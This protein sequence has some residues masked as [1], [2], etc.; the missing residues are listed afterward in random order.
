MSPRKEK[1]DPPVASSSEPE[2]KTSPPRAKDPEKGEE[3]RVSF[4]EKVIQQHR[5]EALERKSAVKLVAADKV[6][7]KDHDSEEEKSSEK[8]KGKGK[9]K[10]KH[11]GKG[12]GGKGKGQSQ[13][14]KSGSPHGGQWR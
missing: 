6:E 2:K 11:R 13:S 4:N 10:R 14:G 7:K 9:K 12:K 8:G 1:A 3:T 5:Q